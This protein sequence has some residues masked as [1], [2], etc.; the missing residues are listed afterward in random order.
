MA[1]I[2]RKWTGR[3][4]RAAAFAESRT[5][6]HDIPNLYRRVTVVMTDGVMFWLVKEYAFVTF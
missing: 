4:S 1:G 6:Q 2:A 5:R 3:L